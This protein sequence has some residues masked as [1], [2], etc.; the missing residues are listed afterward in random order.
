MASLVCSKPTTSQHN[1]IGTCLIAI[2]SMTMMMMM[3]MMVIDM[4]VI[5]MM[6]TIVNV[7]WLSSLAHL[8]ALADIASTSLAMTAGITNSIAIWMLFDRIPGL[9][10]SGIIVTQYGR[11]QID[12]IG[13]H[14]I[15][16][17]L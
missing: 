3:M 13:L 9:Y 10:G 4:M 14:C 12:C 1:P 6:E 11:V 17:S 16:C 2:T 7:D 8:L 15:G 5:D